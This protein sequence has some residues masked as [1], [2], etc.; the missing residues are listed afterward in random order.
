MTIVPARESD[1]QEV[2][3]LWCRAFP[4]RRSVEDRVRMLRE[5]GHYGGLETV[6]VARAEDRRLLG[7]CK[8]YRMEQHLAG[9]AMPMMGLAAVAVPES[10]RRRGVGA[11]LCTEA[12]RV[13]AGRGDLLSVLYP[14]RPDYYQRLG[15][16]L[17]GELHDHRFMT[18]A[19]PEPDETARWVRPGRLQDDSEGIAACYRRVAERSNGPIA[20][21]RKVWAYRLAGREIGVEPAMEDL[22]RAAA[23]DPKRRVVVY[24]DDGISGYALLRLAGAKDGGT[25]VLEIREL[26]AE[27]ESAY[28]GLL[29]YLRGRAPE[30]PL[31]RHFARPEELFGDRLKDPRPPGR[32]SVR[33]LY[34]RTAC[35]ARGPMLRVLR[36]P[37][38]LAARRWFDAGSPPADPA[39]DRTVRISVSDPQRPANEGPWDV[40]V[41]GRHG[42]HLRPDLRRGDLSR[43]GRPP[44][45][46]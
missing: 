4:A 34:F 7:A 14:F 25:G 24:D 10:E 5:G 18:E 26:V 36:V 30:W 3:E 9:V 8:V 43:G 20:R 39:V 2:A 40:R 22:V 45:P 17:V 27:T 33:S 16:G 6:L 15:W 12:I 32:S 28:R 31:A 37:E 41:P 38:A 19:L 23:A 35:L 13:A 1:I 21:D 29:G 46:G 42:L 11:H 44:R